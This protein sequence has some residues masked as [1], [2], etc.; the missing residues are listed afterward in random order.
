MKD[1]DANEN[2]S[3]LNEYHISCSDNLSASKKCEINNFSGDENS[4][5]CS[6]VSGVSSLQIKACH[7]D[8]AEVVEKR[9]HCFIPR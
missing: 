7:D 6:N 3:K 4:A 9:R 1:P 8:N 5:S 2:V